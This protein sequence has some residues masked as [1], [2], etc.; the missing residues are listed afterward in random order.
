VETG[1]FQGGTSILLLKALERFDGGGGRR[2]WAAD[3]FQGTPAPDEVHD[4]AGAA[5]S[6][7]GLRRGVA[8][9]YASSLPTFRANLAR[10]RVPTPAHR[11]RILPGWFNETLAA[12][13]I[14]AISFL[15]LDGDLYASTRDA[16][17][18]LYDKL[19]P[20]GLIY[21]DDYGSYAGCRAA[22]DEFRAE[23]AILSPL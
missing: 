14:P 2:L 4:G 6:G 19:S 3:S 1:V 11:L 23:R 7:G 5:A 16:L 18:A 15:R 13:P 17:E 20:G 8:G 21:V 12:A 9:E 22:V 10:F